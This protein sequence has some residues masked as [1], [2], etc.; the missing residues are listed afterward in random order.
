MKR[1]LFNLASVA[2]LLLCIAIVAWW[3]RSY[4][5]QDSVAW[6]DITVDGPQAWSD[7]T[8]G[9]NSYCGV[10]AFYRSEGSAWRQG[11]DE[12]TGRRLA[13]QGH[14]VLTPS[15]VWFPMR[16]GPRRY[17]YRAAQAADKYVGFDVPHWLFAGIA[18]IVPFLRSGRFLH[19]YRRPVGSC[20]FCG[21]DLR[22]TPD[23]CP[24][25]GAVP[26][27]K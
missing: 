23:R 21:Y 27:V 24:E 8:W 4:R 20:R 7:K 13:W 1:R 25:C 9:A 26:A 3:V 6:F 11:R 19:E 10:V 5:T 18:S 2:S 22:A 15:Q 12:T 16:I 14:P 17:E